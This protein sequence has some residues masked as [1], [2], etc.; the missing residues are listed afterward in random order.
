MGFGTFPSVPDHRM[1]AFLLR[2]PL[3]DR[4]KALFFIACFL[5]LFTV[6]SSGGLS[7]PPVFALHSGILGTQLRFHYLVH[8]GDIN[9]NAIYKAL[10]FM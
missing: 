6:V 9:G 2:R 10:L 5:F 3:P 8:L 4:T 7:T 1:V